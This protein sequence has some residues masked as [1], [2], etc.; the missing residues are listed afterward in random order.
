M[1]GKKVWVASCNSGVLGVFEEKADAM[2]CGKE[3]T[4]YNDLDAWVLEYTIK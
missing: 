4:Y 1:K 2:A 3:Y